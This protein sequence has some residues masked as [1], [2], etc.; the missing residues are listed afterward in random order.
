MIPIQTNPSDR[1]LRQFAGIW[2]PLFA[3]MLGY[4]LISAFELNQ[5][6][7]GLWIFA[8]IAAVVGLI[9]PRAIKFLFVGL[10][11]ATFP[12]GFVVSHVI[13]VLLYYVIL[14]PLGI[15]LRVMGKDPMLKK[16][17]PNASSYWKEREPVTTSDVYFR[18]F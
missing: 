2:F 14:S 1:Q 15:L 6:A 4:I 5:V 12:I 3:A 10:M 8:G 7:Y 9:V 11:F 13:L 17:D 18:Q 16:P